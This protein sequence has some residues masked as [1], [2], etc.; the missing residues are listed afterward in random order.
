M[1]TQQE[2]EQ[3]QL[4]ETGDDSIRDGLESADLCEM[5]INSGVVRKI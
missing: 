2:P 4:R 5:Q 3:E 1:R